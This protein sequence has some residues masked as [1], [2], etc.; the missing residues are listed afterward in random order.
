MLVLAA[1]D[2]TGRR[3][4]KATAARRTWPTTSTRWPRTAS[5][6]TSTTSTRTAARPRRARR[7]QPLQRRHL[8]HGRRR[9][10]PASRGGAGHRSRLAIDEM[11]AVRDYLNEGGTVLYTG[12]YAGLQ[13]AQRVRVQPRDATQPC[14]PDDARR[15]RLPWA[16]SDDFLQYWFG[17]YVY[18]DGRRARPRTANAVRRRRRGRSR[19]T[20]SGWRSA[21]RAPTTRTTRARSSRPAASCRRRSY[22]QFDS[23]AAAKYERPGGPFDPH[24]GSVL[25]VLAHRRHHATSA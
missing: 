11:L 18:N 3:R 21:R 7:A 10:S 8:V 20:G 25:R 4:C 17:A 14:D 22:P 19:S 16:L 13:Y 9:R 24:T 23:W 6:P 1:E 15:R 12:K 5:A 2:Y